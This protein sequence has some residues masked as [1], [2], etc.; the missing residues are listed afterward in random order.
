MNMHDIRKKPFREQLKWQRNLT[1]F[2]DAELGLH[3]WWESVGWKRALA[4]LRRRYPGNRKPKSYCLQRIIKGL[5][6]R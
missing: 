4:E 1:P 2:Y 3:V 5:G 6:P